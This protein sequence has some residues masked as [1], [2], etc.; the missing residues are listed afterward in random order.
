MDTDDAFD[1]EQSTSHKYT[2]KDY[3]EIIRQSQAEI[4]QERLALLAARR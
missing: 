3:L 4:H 1:Y 2:T